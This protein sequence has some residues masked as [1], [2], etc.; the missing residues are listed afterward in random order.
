MKILD[1]SILE[2]IIDQI[3][4]GKASSAIHNLE[5]LPEV[6][7]EKVGKGGCA[8]DCP[9]HDCE[10]EGNNTINIPDNCELPIL[11]MKEEGN[12]NPHVII[13]PNK[14]LERL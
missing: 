12:H 4:F 8:L 13:P 6:K 7:V 14:K 3:R 11:I 10:T 2:Q 1:K 9:W 5:Q